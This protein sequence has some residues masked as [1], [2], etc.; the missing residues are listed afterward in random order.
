[1]NQLLALFIRVEKKEGKTDCILNCNF[2]L[3]YNLGMKINSA[4][5]QTIIF[6]W[7]SLSSLVLMYFLYVRPPAFQKFHKSLS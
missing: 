1:M 5:R 7:N 3:N 4:A 2:S 6:L